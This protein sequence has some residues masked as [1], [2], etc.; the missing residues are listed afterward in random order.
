VVI[1]VIVII[2]I[3]NNN[4][5]KKPTEAVP[6]PLRTFGRVMLEVIPSQVLQNIQ[7]WL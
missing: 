3:I 4:N 7:S 6:I 2:I 5:V 1:I